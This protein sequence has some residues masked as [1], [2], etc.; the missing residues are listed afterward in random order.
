MAKQIPRVLHLYYYSRPVPEICPQHL[1]KIK[2]HGLYSTTI[3]ASIFMRL[4]VTYPRPLCHLFLRL[5]IFF[6]DKKSSYIS[7]H[8][9]IFY[10]VVLVLIAR[11]RHRRLPK[12]T[13][14]CARLRTTTHNYAQL[15]TMVDFIV[16]NK[17]SFH[18]PRRF[19]FTG[20][21]SATHGLLLSYCIN[22]NILTGCKY[23]A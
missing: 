16:I 18:G 10:Y 6:C 14:N 7:P 22:V 2:P 8:F 3:I 19:I 21:C 4:D 17:I 12:T 15:S 13:H 5:S 23:M 1:K 9:A 11:W 20:S